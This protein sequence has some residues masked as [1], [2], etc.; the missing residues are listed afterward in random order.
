[1]SEQHPAAYGDLCACETVE[2]GWRPCPPSLCERSDHH[3][4]EIVPLYDADLNPINRD[5]DQELDRRDQLRN[6]GGG[7]GLNGG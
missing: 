6:T 5:N 2:E 7:R 4:G 3:H 1:M